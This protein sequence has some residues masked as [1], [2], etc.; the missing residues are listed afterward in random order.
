MDSDM[1]PLNRLIPH[2]SGTQ[3]PHRSERESMRA[4]IGGGGSIPS[5]RPVSSGEAQGDDIVTEILRDTENSEPVY[6]EQNIHPSEYQEPDYEVPPHPV[7]RTVRFEDE[8]RRS[9]SKEKETKEP[10]E[11]T[12]YIGLILDEMKLPLIVAV[13]I[14]GASSTGLDSTIG[15]I[16]PALMNDGNL[17]YGGIVLKA[18]I[19]ALLFYA[20]RRIFL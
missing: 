17:G 5:M 16:I 12:D 14:L 19:G 11:D 6:Q 20:L 2:T 10:K 1:T 3:E 15:R 7:E 4:N 8:E 18:V 9:P 13:L